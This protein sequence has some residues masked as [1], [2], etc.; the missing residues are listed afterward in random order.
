MF[1]TVVID[2]TATF[3]DVTMS[4]TSWMQLLSLSYLERIVLAV[5]EVVV[6]ETGRHRER[7]ARTTLE[8]FLRAV[9]KLPKSMRSLRDLGVEV[10]WDPP[11]SPVVPA[12]PGWEE[13]AEEVRERLTA[14]LG[15][16]LPVPDVSHAAVLA[17]DLSGRKPFAASGKG[18]RD[19][20]IWESVKTVV[21]DAAFDDK[22]IFVTDNTGDYCDDG[23]VLHPDLGRELD[24][25]SGR[26]TIVRTLH[27][28][29]LDAD[30]APSVRGLAKDDAA[31]HDHMQAWLSHSADD[32][33]DDGPTVHQLV[34]RS[35]FGACDDLAGQAVQ[36]GPDERGHG[37]FDLVEIGLPDE[38]SEGEIDQALPLEGTLD[39]QT[40]ETYEG[41]T[42]L[43]QA[44]VLADLT[45]A[46]Y[47]RKGDIPYLDSDRVTVVDGDWNDRV[48]LVSASTT[49]RLVFQ[50]RV[51]SGART[52]DDVQFEGAE[53][54]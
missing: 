54:V 41:G 49:A 20:L 45:V 31:L 39:W 1:V 53:A 24:G 37:G 6:M 13:A 34:E 38:M 17:R 12:V 23:G 7:Q 46:G 19:C 8:A 25:S 5:P 42:L 52:V 2:S 11:G 18:Y 33:R 4:G 16:V 22:V 10:E 51:E 26:L 14:L 40:Y 3:D 44:T 21:E 27:D 43:V 15:R 28:L 50:L 47:V 32:S 35:V 36:S 9:A 48:A 29:M 30:V